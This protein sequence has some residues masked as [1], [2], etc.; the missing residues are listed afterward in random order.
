MNSLNFSQFND[1]IKEVEQ[2]GADM[3]SV[4]EH[5]VDG[6]VLVIPG[7]DQSGLTRLFQR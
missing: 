6:V 3:D 2:L 1:L 4:T 7:E 5:V